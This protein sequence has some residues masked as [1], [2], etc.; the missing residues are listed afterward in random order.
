MADER[1]WV[2][3]DTELN[4]YAVDD[5]E[6]PLSLHDL[7]T[8]LATGATVTMRANPM[9]HN[10]GPELLMSFLRGHPVKVYAMRN[11]VTAFDDD[12]RFGALNALHPI[13]S[14][15]P[16][17]LDRAFDV[18][19]GDAA[20]RYRLDPAPGPPASGALLQLSA[21]RDGSAPSP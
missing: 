21:S 4:G 3:Y 16:S 18:M 2:Y 13:L 15:L 12:R 5:A 10:W 7:D 19:T 9:L 20:V 6:R 17:P 11:A 8:R 14:R 1:R